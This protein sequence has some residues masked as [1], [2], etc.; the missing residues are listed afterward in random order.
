M[1]ESDDT[2]GALLALAHMRHRYPHLKQHRLQLAARRGV[3]WLLE[4]QNSDGGW[5][6]FCRGWSMLAFDRSATDVTAHAVRALA[7]WE[8][9]WRTDAKTAAAS[10]RPRRTHLGRH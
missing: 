7:A 10:D 6:T 4:L 2:A 5:P 3:E 1:P 9:A 8:K